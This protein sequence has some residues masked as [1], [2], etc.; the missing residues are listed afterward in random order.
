[1]NSRLSKSKLRRVKAVLDEEANCGAYT[2]SLAKAFGPTGVVYA[3][4]A[5]PESARYVKDTVH[6]LRAGGFRC[7][8][9]LELFLGQF[10]TS[11]HRP[12]ADRCGLITYGQPRPTRHRSPFTHEYWHGR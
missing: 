1:M 4:V 6:A 10:Y 2:D 5:R 11:E 3:F 8:F 7:C 12:G 9:A